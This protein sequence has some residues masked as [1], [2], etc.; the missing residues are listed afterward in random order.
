MTPERFILENKPPEPKH[1]PAGYLRAI[2]RYEAELDLLHPNWRSPNLALRDFSGDE[3]S[4]CR[5]RI[6]WLLKRVSLLRQGRDWRV[7]LAWHGSNP[8]A[9]PIP[10]DDQEVRDGAAQPGVWGERGEQPATPW[11]AREIEEQ[12][13]RNAAARGGR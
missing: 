10:P 7:A 2:A 11:S 8:F 5:G 6:K 13:D 1:L 9:H 12:M 4:P 3:F